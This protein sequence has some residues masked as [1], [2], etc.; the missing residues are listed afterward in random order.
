MTLE[1]LLAKIDD[2]IKSLEGQLSAELL[3]GYSPRRADHNITLDGN[4]VTGIVETLREARE[5]LTTK[6]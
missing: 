1:D 4:A 6:A 3:Y 5:C 2:W